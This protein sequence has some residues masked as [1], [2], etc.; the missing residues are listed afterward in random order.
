[1][2]DDA[3]MVILKDQVINEK[4]DKVLIIA[5]IFIK[6]HFGVPKDE[7]SFA[8]SNT[9]PDPEHPVGGQL[10]DH[11]G[12]DFLQKLHFLA[13]T[14]T[15]TKRQKVKKTRRQKDKKTKRQKDNT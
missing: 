3:S 2:A 5:I 10:K 4:I 11:R 15:K 12:G 6:G 7:A 13:K 14:K 1:M 8:S 9:R